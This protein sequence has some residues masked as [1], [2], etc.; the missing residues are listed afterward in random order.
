MS[1][2]EPRQSMRRETP[3][4]EL[5]IANRDLNLPKKF[6][7]NFVRTSKY[8]AIDFLPVTLLLQFKR[9][10]NIYF[11]LIAILQS[12]PAISPL[13]PVTAI[14]PFAFVLCLSMLREGLEDLARHRADNEANA[15]LTRI[16]Q[17]GKFVDVQWRNVQVGDILL[18]K[19]QEFLPCDI[20]VIASSNEGGVCFIETSSL[21]GEKN[22]KPKG[23]PKETLHFYNPR[24]GTVRLEGKIKCMPPNPHLYTFEG[25]L[26]VG[27][28]NIILG[29]KQL[30]LRGSKLKNT[31]WVVGV[32]VYTGLDTKTMRNAEPARPKISAIESLTNKLI[33][34]IL[35]FQITLCMILAVLNFGWNL[36]YL[37]DNYYL[38][39]EHSAGYEAFLTYWSYF[40]LLNTMIPISLIVTLELVKLC[41]AFFIDKDEDMYNK[42]K[43]RGAKV[44]SCS[45][46]EELGQ[47]EYIFSDKTGTLTCN[48]ME[49]KIAVI[50]N[51]YYGDHEVLVKRK[52]NITSRRPSVTSDVFSEKNEVEACVQDVKLD[53]LLKG[54]GQNFP[55]ELEMKNPQRTRTLYKIKTQQD[56]AREYLTILATCHECVIEEID[57][58]IGYQVKL[59]LDFLIF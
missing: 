16:Y 9:Y 34:G 19:E 55:A 13:N 48:M 50:G 49:F 14:V 20:V 7:S 54:V 45:I 22:L 41:Q 3:Q 40:L 18:I 58:K 39:K 36:L 12:I 38:W 28:E 8:S 57:G 53:S 11:L 17:Q 59:H 42:A 5:F 46:N 44:F 31:E 2:I 30:L 24:T 25:T 21:D 10:A 29:A 1:R 35:V 37:E 23:A 26:T 15:S 4:R 51:E 52:R 56:L 47:V 27:Q 6:P 33:F 43:G 32:A